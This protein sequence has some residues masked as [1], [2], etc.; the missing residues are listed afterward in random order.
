MINSIFRGSTSPKK[1]A[2]FFR[3]GYDWIATMLETIVWEYPGTWWDIDGYV[4]K[5]DCDT[6]GQPS[7]KSGNMA[8]NAGLVSRL[9]IN[10]IGSEWG[11]LERIYF[12]AWFFGH[13]WNLDG[14]WGI[15]QACNS[16]SYGTPNAFKI[17]IWDGCNGDG[18]WMFK[19]LGLPHDTLHYIILK[20]NTHRDRFK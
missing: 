10:E 12:Q 15:P 1:N 8:I 13:A 11:C 17:P 9:A 3:W 18:L 7:T 4:W 19:A 2:V 5:L 6:W 16:N 20:W 14:T